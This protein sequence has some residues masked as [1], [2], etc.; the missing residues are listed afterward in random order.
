[1]PIFPVPAAMQSSS[2]GFYPNNIEGSLRF[3]DD[4]SAYLSWTPASA[5]NRKTWT[6]SGWVKRGEAGDGTGSNHHFF[7][8]ASTTQ[9]DFYQNGFRFYSD[10]GTYIVVASQKLRDYSAWYHIVVAVDTT[11]ATASDRFKIYINGEQV[12]DFS[13]TTYPPLNHDTAINST[14]AHFIGKNASTNYLHAYVAEVHFTDGTAYDADAF[15]ELKN[16]VWVAKT[17]DVTYGTNGFHLNFQ[18]DA[19]VEAF[20][21]VLYRGTGTANT[22]VTGTGFKPDLIWGKKTNT[23][24]SHFLIDSVRSEQFTL[25]SDSTA[26]EA[27]T[28]DILTS[29]DSDG[30]TVGANGQSNA[31]GADFVA[32]CWDAGANNTPTGH[33]SVLYKAYAAD[34]PHK[35]S[36][37]GFEP[38]LLWIK[39]RNNVESHYLFDSVRGIAK[40]KWLISNDI[41]AEAQTG[42]LSCDI[43]THSDGFFFNNQSVNSGELYFNSRTYVAWGWDAGTGNPVSNTD[44]SITS[45]VKA[46]TT[47]GFSIVKYTGA[48]GSSDT[49]GHGLAQAPELTIIKGLA[50]SRY[51]DVQTQGKRFYL[52][53]NAADQGDL[54]HTSGASTI[55]LANNNNFW[56]ASSENYIMYCFHSVS[57]YSKIGAYTGTGASGNTVTTGFRPGFVMIKKNTTASWY[58]FDG[59]RDPFNDVTL[60]LF[61]DLTAAEVDSATYAIE[62]TDT[63]FTV[64]GTNAG[65]NTN[66]SEYIYAAF[67]GSYSDYITDVNTDGTID[68]RV[69]AS[70]T[71]GF[72]IVSYVGTGANATVGHGLSSAPDWIVIKDRPTVNDWPVWHTSLANTEYLK[73]NN[74]NV[75]ATGA[76][77]WNSTSPTATTFSLGSSNLA[78]NSGKEHIAYCWTATTGVSAFGSYEGNGSTDGPEVDCGFVPAFVMIKDIGRAEHWIIFDAT[79]ETT[80]DRSSRLFASSNSAESDIPSDQGIRFLSTA[81]GD[82]INGFKITTNS[83]GI[84]DN[85]DPDVTKIYA[86]F[87]DTREAAFWL[88]QS[89]NDN[90]WQPVNLDHNDTLLD[91]PTDNFATWNGVVPGNFTLS[92]GNLKSTVGTN[93]NGII[94]SMGFDPQD[95]AGFKAEFT[96]NTLGNM[97]IGLADETFKT[98]EGTV[99]ATTQARTVIYGVDGTVYDNGSSQG[100]FSSFIAGDVVTMYVK[101]GSFYYAVNGTL[102]NSGSAVVTGITDNTVFWLHALSGVTSGTLTAN[103]G[104]QPFKYTTSLDV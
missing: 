28:A 2:R 68:S 15:G 49:V 64:N 71:T 78:N 25:S 75:K 27:T 3:N 9:C 26:V 21:T 83:Y 60:G 80:N 33:S 58:I 63:G 11:Q 1:M 62:F 47:N 61:P 48:G 56:N 74:T 73:F 76:T 5:G 100:T 69:K 39:N 90:D 19:E 34:G 70:D 51:W 8:S 92:E 4:D 24:G 31:N 98:D 59:T 40:D 45:T 13:S 29:I 55:Q 85:V 97:V 87:A 6:W 65:I 54:I 10:G 32:W 14:T 30:F 36:G 46:S 53:S 89:G 22:G 41:Y 94:S 104:Q 16:G 95:S 35:V 77:V 43:S 101:S 91:S 12:T 7:F 81:N 23:T 72:S 66:T 82:L 50:A 96:I 42:A 17:P 37:M 52:N 38:D 99:F 44:G 67:K 84:N 79:R 88:D 103:F 18:D 93:R 102:A 86:A 20:N 57:G